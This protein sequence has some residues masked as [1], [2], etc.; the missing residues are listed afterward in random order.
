DTIFGSAGD[1]TITGGAGDD[2]ID[3]GNGNDDI[4]GGTGDDTINGGFGSDRLFGNDGTDTINGGPDA[5]YLDGGD[6][7][8]PD[9]L[10]GGTGQDTCLERTGQETIVGG[11]ENLTRA[12]LADFGLG[13]VD[14]KVVVSWSTL[15]ESGTVGFHVYRRDARTGDFTQVNDH[16]LVAIHTAPEGGVYR[17]V[18]DTAEP[19]AMHNYVIVEQESSGQKRFYGPYNR[20]ALLNP[21]ITM[22][23]GLRYAFAPRPVAHRIIP[24]VLRAGVSRIRP[25]HHGGVDHAKVAVDATGLVNLTLSDLADSMGL[26]E[27]D[28]LTRINAGTLAIKLDGEPVAWTAAA[29]GIEFYGRAAK[30]VYSTDRVYY[31]EANAGSVMATENVTAPGGVAGTSFRAVARAEED[32]FA[33]RVVPVDPESDYWFWSVV[34]PTTAG[35]EKATVTVSSAGL[36]AGAGDATL[37]I[38]LHGASN[39]D[40]ADEHTVSVKV[41]GVSVGTGAFEG[42]EAKTLSF[43]VPSGVLVDGDNTI[44]V[45]G[46][47]PSGAD[48]NIMYLNAAELEYDR[49]YVASGDRFEFSAENHG[50][51]E[52][53]GLST[54]DVRVFD[55]TDA[56]TPKVVSGF[57]VSGGGS[58]YAVRFAPVTG[59]KYLVTTVAGN[60]PADLWTDAEVDLTDAKTKAEYV[61]ITRGDFF[62]AADK[63]AQFRASTGLTTKVV[64]LEDIYDAFSNGQ[65]NPHA[66]QSFLAYANEHWATAPKYVVLAGAG[67]YDYKNIRGFGGNIIPPLEVSTSS[68]L[69]ASDARFADIVDDDG[70]PDL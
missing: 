50:V 36:A 45:I 14:G 63:L 24:D 54:G 60:A 51:V 37:R 11:C 31:V 43:N 61:V 34:S 66:I 48:S 47:L 59:A 19:G 67:H 33:A 16:L 22:A 15:A 68:G 17:F 38:E 12:M 64:D 46:V 25:L 52:V 6:D 40:V 56:E 32:V 44:E 29:D 57:D 13:V 28:A 53:T 9:N 5:D 42:F 3:G 49:S 30:S 39:E 21:R 55:V 35:R 23:R 1:D 20:A 8:S 4:S 2:V 58:D 69:F 7:G 41:N 62:E 27:S 18:D 10:D 70:V 26:T 65:P